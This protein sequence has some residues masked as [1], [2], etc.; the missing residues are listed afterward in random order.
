MP[1]AFSQ[2]L[3]GERP[4]RFIHP[5]VISQTVVP[6]T[7]VS[8]FGPCCWN[9]QLPQNLGIFQAVVAI[10]KLSSVRPLCRAHD[11]AIFMLQLFLCSGMASVDYSQ[12]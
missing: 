11:K 1:S 8:E 12:C 9:T 10:S 4:G 3:R 7:W 5:V 2:Q 6:V